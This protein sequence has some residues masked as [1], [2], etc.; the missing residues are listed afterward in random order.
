MSRRHSPRSRRG[1]SALE[2]ALSLPML[3][4][5]MLAIIDLGR[6]ISDTNRATSAAAAVA[7]LV[8]QTESFVDKP[9]P[10]TV[11]TGK[12]LG[13]ANI[14]A[15]EVATPLKLFTD[16]VVI[17]T[18]ISNDGAGPVVSWVR[19]W[20]RTDINSNVSTSKMRGI[21]LVKGEAAVFA[22]VGYK[23]HPFLLSGK[24]L[25]LDEDQI[26]QTTAVR[27]PRLTG[28]KLVPA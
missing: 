25:G 6:F 7:D 3:L 16:G 18:V 9:N 23:F 11:A 24:L 20:G 27:R 13:V 2:L 5:F 12:E 19:R 14:A 4:G 22:E 21:V 26:F 17:I 15:R 1:A 28:P 10:D 8:S